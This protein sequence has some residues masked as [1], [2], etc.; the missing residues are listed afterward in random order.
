MSRWPAKGTH[1]SPRV[2]EPAATNSFRTRA[3]WR[4]WDDRP[5]LAIW[6]G[7]SQRVADFGDRIGRSHRPR[8]KVR[9]HR[10]LLVIERQ[11]EE[12]RKPWKLVRVLE[13]PAIQ[14]LLRL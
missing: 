4:A 13:R 1:T 2:R 3:C 9:Q 5:T 10:H 14:S 11:F 12:G 8:R 7:Q 6:I